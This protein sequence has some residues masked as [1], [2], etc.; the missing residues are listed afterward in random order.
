MRS[1]MG[2]GRKEG[3]WSIWEA[4]VQYGWGSVGQLVGRSVG[5]DGFL[6]PG[7]GGRGWG[8]EGA[9]VG[10]HVGLEEF[11]RFGSYVLDGHRDR[12]PT[13]C[14]SDFGINQSNQK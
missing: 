14:N 7:P 8:A 1:D 10:V 13:K 11:G 2:M 9:G 5:D 12:A 3:A 4:F 6:D